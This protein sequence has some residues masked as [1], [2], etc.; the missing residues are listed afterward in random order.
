VTDEGLSIDGSDVTNVLVT[1]TDRRT[2]ISGVVIDAAGR[3]DADAS[4]VAFPADVQSWKQGSVG[5]QRIQS[6]R[7][8]T[9]GVYTLADLPPG[10]C[11]VAAV[12]DDVLDGWQD[13]RTLEA[14]SRIAIRVTLRDGESVSQNVTTRSVR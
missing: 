11:F 10:I 8:A 6:A 4:V 7:A 9:N 13:T 2:Q 5:P 3:P 1:L 14:M 12:K